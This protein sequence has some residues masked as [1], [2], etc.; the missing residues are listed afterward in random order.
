MIVTTPYPRDGTN[1]EWEARGRICR[2]MRVN[3]GNYMTMHE[4]GKV[5]G[6]SEYDVSKMENGRMDPAPLE[7]YWRLA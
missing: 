3:F 5:A 6:F 4:L 2:D 1:P 7:K